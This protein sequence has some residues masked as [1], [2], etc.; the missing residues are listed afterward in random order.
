VKVTVDRFEGEVAVLLV[1]PEE[2]QQVLVPRALLPGVREGDI[3]E[4]T[5]R[6]E[7]GE[8]RE[9]RERAASLIERLRTK[10]E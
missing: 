3:L 9:A 4:L 10:G 6:K 5:L 1:R 2:T 8:T 7:E